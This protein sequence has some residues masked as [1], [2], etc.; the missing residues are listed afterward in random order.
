M[1]WHYE[2]CPICNEPAD[3]RGFC[4]CE[5]PFSLNAVPQEKIDGIARTIFPHVVA[6]VEGLTGG[7]AKNVLNKKA[8]ATSQA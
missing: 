3:N 4:G 7:T 5:P 1:A 2:I 8:M 6:Y